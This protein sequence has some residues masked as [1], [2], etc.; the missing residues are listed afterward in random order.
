MA[1]ATT[2]PECGARVSAY[3][4]GCE[5]CGADLEAHARRRRLQAADE[6]A[7]RRLPRL[8]WERIPLSGWEAVYLAVTVFAVIWISVVGIVLGLLG[9]MHG[10]YEDRRGWTALCGA[11][12]A[13]ALALE[14]SRL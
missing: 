5:S 2:C 10:F 1:G 3:A 7:T 11:L 14:L 8:D 12:A 9:A 6:V 13:V 4:A